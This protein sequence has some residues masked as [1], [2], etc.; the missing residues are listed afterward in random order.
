MHPTAPRRNRSHDEAC[1][2]AVNAA[3]GDGHLAVPGRMRNTRAARV[4]GAG[5]ISMVPR[6][7]A[8]FAREILAHEGPLR[9]YLRRF[10]QETADVEDAIQDTYARILGLSETEQRAIRS[11]YAFVMTTGRNVA[12]DWLRRRRV[13]SIELMAELDSLNVSDEGPTA[14]EQVSAR[15][16]L[17]LLRSVIATLPERCRQV[18]TLRKLF[19]LS[20]KQIAAQLG[21]SENTVEKQVATGVRLCAER[22][23]GL[24]SHRPELNATVDMSKP[25]VKR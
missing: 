21:I 2:E 24:R 16:E 8:W 6:Q 13:V 15:Q 22:M 11:P 23:H 9:G 5:C 25:D 14:F 12:L 19:G 10:L 3:G 17:E 7:H 4:S 20:Q 1:G 18:L